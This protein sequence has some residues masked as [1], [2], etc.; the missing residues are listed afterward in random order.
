MY[1]QYLVKSR[2]TILLILV[3]HYGFL[4]TSLIFYSSGSYMLWGLSLTQ[5]WRKLTRSLSLEMAAGM[6]DDML[7]CMQKVLSFVQL[8]MMS[9][10]WESVSLLQEMSMV[11]RADRVTSICV[12]STF[13]FLFRNLYSN[14]WEIPFSCDSTSRD[15]EVPFSIDVPRYSDSLMGAFLA[16]EG[17]LPTGLSRRG[18]AKD[19]FI[20]RMEANNYKCTAS[21]RNN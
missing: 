11:V 10:I 13:R 20:L 6:S 19:F 18:G 4:E 7:P 5:S 21:C 2:P 9:S 15:S 16:R 1:W 12:G 3:T 8:F 17:L 14:F